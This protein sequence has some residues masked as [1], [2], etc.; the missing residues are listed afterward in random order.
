YY[1]ST[2]SRWV[3]TTGPTTDR[4]NIPL[5]LDGAVVV[6]RK[7]SAMILTFIGR[8]PDVRFRTSI[9]NAGPTYLH[10]GFPT[11]VTLG[12]LAMQ[13]ALPGWISAAVADN[14]DTLSVSTG[15]DWLNYFHNGTFWQRT[16]GPATNRDGI[17]I[18][19]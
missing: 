19:A 14:A 15:A 8:V 17:V 13:T 16:T 5:P 6:T 18:L 4:G 11:D 2:L 7:A 12:A 3:R 9:H 1:H 10:T